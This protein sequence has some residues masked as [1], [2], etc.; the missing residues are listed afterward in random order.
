[1]V[2]SLV[3]LSLRTEG[4]AVESVPNARQAVKDFDAIDPDVLI[5]DIDLGDRPNGIELAAILRTQA[6]YIG[7]VFLTNFPSMDA[8]DSSLKP[9][10]RSSF[11]HKSAVDG[12]GVLRQAI[13]SSLDDSADP[14]VLGLPEDHPLSA[15]SATQMSLLRLVAEGWSNAQIAE[16][17]GGTLRATERLLSRTFRSLDI[18]DDGSVNARVTAT[19]LYVRTFGVP[20]P[21]AERR[22]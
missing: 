13:E 19:R 11:I 16:R 8:V 18:P 1:M 14:L 10:P 20:E 6:P 7:V 4:F 5:T 22:P 3:E 15:L 2:R 12:P 21:L 9:P 17:R